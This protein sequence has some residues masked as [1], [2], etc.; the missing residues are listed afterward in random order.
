VVERFT[1]LISDTEPQQRTMLRMALDATQSHTELPLRQG[2]AIGWITEALEPLRGALTDAQVHQ[3][4]LA[5]R[6]ATGIEARVW[7]TDVAQLSNDDAMA[8][9]RWS[10][11]ALLAAALAGQAP[12]TSAIDERPQRR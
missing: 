6:S 5:I 2:R 11:Q 3:L 8:V 4:V 10:A 1:Q 7:L 9:M 12:P